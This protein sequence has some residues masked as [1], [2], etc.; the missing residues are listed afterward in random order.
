MTADPC[1]LDVS[2]N[3]LPN[4]S[5]DTR[6]YKSF[7]MCGDRIARSIDSDII[8]YNRWTLEEQH[9]TIRNI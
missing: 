3:S 4:L 2:L 7:E 9:V 8:I 5:S 6:S 1:K